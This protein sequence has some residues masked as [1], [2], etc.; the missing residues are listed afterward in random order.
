MFRTN[1]IFCSKPVAACFRH[2]LN[3]KDADIIRCMIGRRLFGTKINE[4]SWAA[5][6]LIK[7]GE[8]LEKG[9][10]LPDVEYTE[11]LLNTPPDHVKN[12][13]NEILALTII[14][15]HQLMT[16]LQVKIAISIKIMF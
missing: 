6:N 5:E 12:L 1:S 16:L 4:N 15:S 7:K 10:E 11:D 8:K 3:I 9:P 14:E 13:C 2:F